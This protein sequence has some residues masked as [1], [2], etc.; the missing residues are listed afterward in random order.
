MAPSL[1]HSHFAAETD[2]QARRLFTS[3]QQQ[4]TNLLRGVPGRLRPPIDDIE[5]YWTPAEKAQT[6]AML[7]YSFVGSQETVR[8]GLAEFVN[9]TGV[10]EVI[11]A[12]AIYDHAARLHSYEILADLVSNR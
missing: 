6:S 11:V 12:S 5:S 4:F 7:T 10:D 9:Q 1:L 3:A 2:E 8:R